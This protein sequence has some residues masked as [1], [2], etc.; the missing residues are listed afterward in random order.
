MFGWFARKPREIAALD[1]AAYSLCE[2]VRDGVWDAALKRV[3]NGQPAASA[4]VIGEVR[5][6]CPGYSTKNYQRAIARGM[7]NSR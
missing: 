4:D 7:V 6:R 3:Q 2:E 5:R 1:L